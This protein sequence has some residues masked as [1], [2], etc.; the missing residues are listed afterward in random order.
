[1]RSIIFDTET[2]G[3]N[4][5]S[6]DKSLGHRI[7]EIGCVEMIDRRITG[8][9]YYQLI[10][11]EMPIDPEAIKVHGIGNDKLL[12]EPTFSQIFPELWNFLSGADELVAHNISFDQ[13]FLNRE[14]S[15]L[16]LGFKLEDKFQLVD[17]LEIA[18]QQFVGQKNNLDALCKRFNI[19]TSNRTYHGALIDAQLLAEVYLKLTSEQSALSLEIGRMNHEQQ[20]ELPNHWLKVQV[21]PDESARHL[22]LVELIKNPPKKD[23]K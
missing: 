10:N 15:L 17:S 11:P 18:K 1:M 9:T 16:N 4:R 3:M 14:L 6:S 8:R 12:Y 20:F 19:D 5:E 13:A 21:S 2:T 23:K 7:I 22:A